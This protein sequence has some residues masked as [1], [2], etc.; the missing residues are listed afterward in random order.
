MQALLQIVMRVRSFMAECHDKMMTGKMSH[1]TG[2]AVVATFV[3]GLM[4]GMLIG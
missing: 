4:I 3:A 2:Y 1:L